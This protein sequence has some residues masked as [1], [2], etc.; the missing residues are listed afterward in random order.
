[1]KITPIATVLCL[2]ALSQPAVAETKTLASAPIEVE[3]NFIGA[4]MQCH[5]HNAGS[6]AVAIKSR[7]ILNGSGVAQ[8][9]FADSCGAAPL[10]PKHSC[11]FTFPT[12]NGGIFVC[13]VRAQGPAIKLRGVASFRPSTSTV[14]M[15]VPIE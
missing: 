7:A 5:I 8:T 11:F 9:L 3:A 15:S 2:A 13:R 4:A 14:L 12:D 6:E 1:M 10:Q